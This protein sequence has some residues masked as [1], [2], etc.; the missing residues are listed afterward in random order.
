MGSSLGDSLSQLSNYFDGLHLTRD[1]YPLFLSLSFWD[2]TQTRTYSLPT[3]RPSSMPL[4]PV[5]PSMLFSLP[6]WLLPAGY[7]APMVIQTQPTWKRSSLKPWTLPT[8]VMDSALGSGLGHYGMV[9][10]K[11]N[12]LLLPPWRL[13]L[14]AGPTTLVSKLLTLTVRET[15]S[16]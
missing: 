8:P 14:L 2:L 12:L 11:L 16:L 7:L 10:R 13:P 4:V 1:A 15:M 3:A 9:R 6:M 5:S